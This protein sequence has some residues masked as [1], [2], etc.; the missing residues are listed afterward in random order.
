[1]T[2]PAFAGYKVRP[3]S[4]LAPN[5]PRLADNIDPQT[6]DFA[7]IETGADPVDA[8]V[9]LALLVVRNSG[10]S[11]AEVGN[12]LIDIRKMDETAQTRAES[13]IRRALSRLVK[14]RDIE[15]SSITWDYWEPGT[16]FGQIRVC[17]K[18]LRK[19]DDVLNETTVPLPHTR[20]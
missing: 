14:N 18:N 11:V 9:V 15:I 20:T 6:R 17:W 3:P 19:M 12:R 8:Q 4:A 7:T 10:P 16:Q 1:M 13:D 5:S 2:I